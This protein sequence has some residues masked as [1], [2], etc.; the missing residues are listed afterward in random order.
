MKYTQLAQII[1]FQAELFRY[2]RSFYFQ[3]IYYRGGLKSTKIY[4][5]NQFQWFLILFSNPPGH[6]LN[7]F[8]EMTW[9]SAVNIYAIAKHHMGI[10]GNYLVR[11]GHG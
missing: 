2:L 10:A 6:N 5:L 9:N 8:T 11:L 4:V 1:P 7:P 3:F